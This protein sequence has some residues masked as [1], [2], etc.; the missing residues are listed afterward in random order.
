[1][2]YITNTLGNLVQQTAFL[3]L[4][5]GN[6]IMIAVACFFLYLAIKHGFEPLLLV[7]IAFGMLLVNIYPDIML[8]A[9]DSANGTG[10]LLYYFFQLDEWS[11]LPSLIFMGVGA[12]TDFGPLIANPASFLLGAAAQFGIFA[13]YLGAMALGFSD[14]AAAAISIIG[15]ADGPTSIFLAG[16][17]QQTALMGPIAV[18]AYSYMSLVPIIQPPIMKLLTTEKERKIKMGQLRPVTQLEKILFPIIVT[19]VV[20]MILPTTAPLV[21]MLMLGNLFKESGVVR[22]LTETASNAMMY[23]VVILLG[24]SVGATTSAE[25]FLNV[26]TL[27]IVLLGLIAFAFGT[28]AGVLFGKLMCVATH[29]KVNPLIGSA[30]VSAV[31]MAARVSQKVGAEADPTNFL[32]MH[33][34]GPN[35]AGVIGT[36]VAAGTFMAISGVMYQQEAICLLARANRGCYRNVRLC[37]QAQKE[38]VRFP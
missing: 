11:I 16:K 9:E 1:M 24:T 31:P 21:G 23:I 30:G 35:V 38:T 25:A 28:A 14:K 10:G 26:S 4:T 20:C 13:A 3:N 19:I 6:Y 2:E 37:Y 29:G 17:L 27:K 36:A 7:P 12:M 15:G 33:A 8:H 22:Q 18:A 32:L 5:W 34:M